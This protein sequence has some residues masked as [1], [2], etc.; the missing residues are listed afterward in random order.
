MSIVDI[1]YSYLPS[2][3]KHTPSGWT[4]FNAVCCSHNGNTLDTRARG[5]MIKNGEG[6][7]YHCFNCGYKASYIPGRHLTRKMRNLLSWMGAH[8]DVISKLSMEALKVE[9]DQ[10]ELEA[11]SLPLLPDRDLPKNCQL[12]LD[13]ASNN[14]GALAAAEYILDRG[15]TLDSYPWMWSP[16]HPDRF[17][18]PFMFEGRTVGWTGRKITDGKP[19]YLSEQTPGYVFNLDQQS[20]DRPYVLV[21]E[22]PLDAISIDAVAILGAD[23]MDKQAMLINR[24]GKRPVLIPDRDKDG[25]RSVERAIELGWAVSMP[26]WESGIK[27]TN[28]A[29]KRHG[30][31][32][33]LYMI[34]AAKEESALK[35]QLAAKNWFRNI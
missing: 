1:I 32:A 4:K 7:S 25:L 15:F 3:R 18:I 31:L 16:E 19:K 8:D 24:L 12:I 22:G 11:V 10:A 13:A 26:Q 30:K 20:Q 33:A 9:S 6:V 27:D 23:I 2:K 14:Q 17:I 5:G 34:M 21:V 28:D 29:V 35:I